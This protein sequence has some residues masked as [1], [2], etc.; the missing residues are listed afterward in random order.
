MSPAQ[1]SPCFPGVHTLLY[2]RHM[3]GRSAA[4]GARLLSPFC[5]SPQPGLL[6]HWLQHQL[7]HRLP[8]ETLQ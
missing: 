7:W 6:Q 4:S 2:E 3:S 1:E 5:Q 8:V